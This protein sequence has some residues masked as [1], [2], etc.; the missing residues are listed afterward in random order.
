MGWPISPD[1]ANPVMEDFEDK[2]LDSTLTK[3]HIWYC[4][5]DNMFMILHEYAIQDFTDHINSHYLNWD[6]NHHLEHKTSV[7]C[8]LLCRTETIVLESQD[9]KEELK[10]VKKVMIVNG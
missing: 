1:V 7:V 8:T 2:A 4:Y 3:L 5:M 10:H 6:S 9:V